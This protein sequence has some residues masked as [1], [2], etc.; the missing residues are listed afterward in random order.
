MKFTNN[1]LR[2]T[3]CV[4][5]VLGTAA[6]ATLTPTASALPVDCS[7]ESL[8]GTVNSVTASAGTYLASHP[9]ANQAIMAVYGQPPADAS[10]TVRGYFT[11]NPGEYHD[12]RG[13]LAPIGEA[14][15]QCN[16]TVLPPVLASAYTQFMAG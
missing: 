10:A 8:Q 5:V 12:L 4:C 13:I 9:G 1:F 3:G 16:T 7:P 6:A 14:Q 11:A 15:R 2:A